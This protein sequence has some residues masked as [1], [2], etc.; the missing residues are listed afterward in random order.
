MAVVPARANQGNAVRP[1][2][3]GNAAAAPAT[4]SGER[5]TISNHWDRQILGR[6]SEA[7]TREP[8]D[9][10]PAMVMRERVGR[11]APKRCDRR[12][13]C[14]IRGERQVVK[15]DARDGLIV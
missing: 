4:V 7:V 1:R 13:V 8:G 2:L 10:L 5:S 3:V 9:L 15:T 12:V 14:R 11:G 6:R